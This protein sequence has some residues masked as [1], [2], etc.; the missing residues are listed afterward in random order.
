MGGSASSS[1]EGKAILKS[2][3]VTSL[4]RDI[5]MKPTEAKFFL[6]LF[7]EIDL[8]KGG[9]ISLAEFY[10]HFGVD[11]TPFADRAFSVLDEDRSGE[12]DYHEFL[13]GVWSLCSA[14]TE[15]LCKFLFSLFDED[16]SHSLDDAEIESALR[17]LHNSDPLPPD[18]QAAFDAMVRSQ[19]R[20]EGLLPPAGGSGGGDG[21]SS[22]YTAI[23]NGHGGGAAGA[24]GAADDDDDDLLEEIEIT[25]DEFLG[26]NSEHPQML[27]PG[28]VLRDALRRMARGRK[29]W[30]KKE[31]LR[32]EMFSGAELDDI[33]F[34]KKRAKAAAEEQ[35][36]LDRARMRKQNIRKLK[37][38]RKRKK[39]EEYQRKV[40]EKF[41]HCTPEESEYREAWKAVA[42]AREVWEEAEAGGASKEDC[43]RLR[44][45]LAQA[46]NDLEECRA[47]I[48]EMWERQKE[49]EQK[50]RTKQAEG[51]VARWLATREAKKEIRRD[52]KK[53]R[54]LFRLLPQVDPVF[55]NFD[56]ISY[57][58]CKRRVADEHVH[59][60]VKK[61]MKAVRKEFRR[62]RKEEERFIRDEVLKDPWVAGPWDEEETES[63]ESEQE[64]VFLDDEDWEMHVSVQNCHFQSVDCRAW[65][66]IVGSV[67]KRILHAAG[68]RIDWR[69][70]QA[71]ENDGLT[72][73]EREAKVEA[74]AR[75][76][77]RA[78]FMASA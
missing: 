50:R 17:M 29:Y 6:N 60:A 51:K 54:W 15:D 10:A 34:A 74:E 58:D 7:Y 56:K 45:R 70:K 20:K 41:E 40:K 3:A 33:L 13:A 68:I 39:E 42:R 62:I 26:Y 2:D 22:K 36:R 32:G 46:E 30:Q 25:V 65:H 75:A 18:I 8:D 72:E 9:S 12:L 59:R 71:D 16:N 57:K 4:V 64:S 69:R 35:A 44:R 52:A 19:L 73:T 28:V 23:D 11:K 43:V 1:R 66:E 67:P 63:E 38:I 77:R 5:G 53:M 49:A 76:K 31:K 47:G 24:A 21:G 37:A 55:A 61:E 48:E 14:S 27:A 78:S